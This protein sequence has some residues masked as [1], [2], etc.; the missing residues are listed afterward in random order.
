MSDISVSEVPGPDPVTRRFLSGQLEI[1]VS[2][3]RNAPG[4]EEIAQ[5][6][7]AVLEEIDGEP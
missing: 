7:R 3:L 2:G 4:D 5:H 1:D 6:L